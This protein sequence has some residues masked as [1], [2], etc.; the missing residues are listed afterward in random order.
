[1]ISEASKLG[2]SVNTLKQWGDEVV[3]NVNTCVSGSKG[4]AVNVAD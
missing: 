1:M 2:N 3:E 4:N